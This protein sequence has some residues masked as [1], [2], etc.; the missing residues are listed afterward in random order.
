M[1]WKSG[2]TK[3]PVYDAKK[4]D[5]GGCPKRYPLAWKTSSGV[6]EDMFVGTGNKGN[7]DN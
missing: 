2:A 4:A 3:E 1:V 6:L 5:S 7:T